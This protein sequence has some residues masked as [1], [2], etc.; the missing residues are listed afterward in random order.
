MSLW[1]PRLRR[2]FAAAQARR[3]AIAS[4]SDDEQQ[5]RQLISLQAV[6][7]DAS[8]QVPHYLK[9][10]ASDQ[11]P[12]VI[13]SWDEFATLPILRR[14][15]LQDRPADFLRPSGPPAGITKTAGS[16]A[17]PIHVGMNQSERDL[18]RIVKLAAWQELGYTPASRLF[19]I[20][21][22]S[23][24]LGTGWRGQV[25]QARRRIGDVALGYQ[26]VSAY[27][28]TPEIAGRFAEQLI[29]FRPVGLIGYASALD[30]FGRYT[31]PLRSRFHELGLRFVLVTTE[32]PP[33]PDT[34]AMLADLFGCR[35][36]QEYGGAEFGQVAF[37]VGS[38]PFNVYHDL[39]YLEA[40]SAPVTDAAAHPLLMTALYPRYTPLIRYRNGDAAAGLHR[41]SNGHVASFDELAG[42]LN[43]VVYL[44]PGDAIHSE[45][46]LHCV[47]HER[48]VYNVQMVLTDAG[49]DLRLVTPDPDRAGL[50][51]R[52]RGRLAQVDR[53]LAAVCFEY[54]DDVAT[55][56]AG[57]RR[58]FV[59]QRSSPP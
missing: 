5:H 16:T 55:T 43:D 49:I 19:I 3:E 18:M 36:V 8:T 4:L 45:A 47:L 30:L 28:M 12:P 17:T 15:H 48:T 42:R 32:R 56:R 10:I 20:W 58:W 21:G 37:Q 7:A 2:Q 26:R 59:D 13:R 33:R 54:V 39:N 29:Q 27:R 46:I 9:L 52:I 22:H 51:T 31:A 6:W 57:K 50:E 53:R 40:E 24:L 38:E 23:H 34:T 44:A 14:S 41:W 11:A 25:L 35:V 1:L